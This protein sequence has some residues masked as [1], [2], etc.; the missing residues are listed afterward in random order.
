MVVLYVVSFVLLLITKP[1]VILR[2]KRLPDT[3]K[4]VAEPAEQN[5][6]ELSP[7]SETTPF[8]ELTDMLCGS[9]LNLG[10]GPLGALATQQ[11]RKQVTR[12][13]IHSVWDKVRQTNPD[14]C[15]ESFQVDWQLVSIY[16][17][18]APVLFF[19]LVVAAI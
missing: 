17:A 16:S 3:E 2:S 11:L 4:I 18:I 19:L 5:P 15:W 1:S 9:S 13:N 8:L 6:R 7:T 10:L 12:E 14:K